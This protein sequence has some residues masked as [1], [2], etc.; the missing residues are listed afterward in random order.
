MSLSPALLP[1]PRLMIRAALVLAAA[2]LA[3]APAA[4]AQGQ[5]NYGSV[6]S[7]YGLGERTEFG[8][9]QAEMLGGAQTALRSTFY[10]GLANPALWADQQVT[11]FSA[12]VGVQGV[13]S[14]DAASTAASRAT[15]GD[16]AG[17]QLG[18]P[19]LPARLGLTFGYRPYSRV[20]YRASIPGRLV[21]EEDTTAYALNQE[22]GG[23][24]QRISGGLGLRVGQALQVG[25]SA[26]VLFGT[27]EYIQRTTFD[28]GAFTEVRQS[29]ATRLSGVSGTL[30]ALVTARSVASGDDALS[31]GL[32]VTL[33]T[34][35]RG[36]QTLTLGQSLDRDTLATSTGGRAT[37][38]LLARGGL[39]YRAGARWLAALDATYEPWSSFT[40]TLPLGGYNEATRV[41]ELRDRYRVGGGIE[42]VPAG[43]N[44][45]ASVLA[46]TAYRLGAYGERGLYAPSGASV[47]TLA[48]TGGL[49]V[50]NRLSGARIDLG[51][52]VGTRGATEGALVRDV[53]ARGSL[54]LNFG[55]RWFVRRRIE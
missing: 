52:E 9:S 12:A 33:P 25:A 53:F 38:P 29:R 32:A 55:E 23:G 49:S 4:H 37:L 39:S 18:V 40:S 36:T 8:S 22:G 28:E 10:N 45:N 13:R 47:Q 51:F 43:R 3:A 24:L 27:V 2:G 30:G 42:V 26:D 48:L 5:N 35:L 19:I 31:L 34:R 1:V 17:L 14:T 46:Q 21:T 6:Y 54:T 20:N 7:R 44:R 16:V 15:A 50:P 11:T 41:D